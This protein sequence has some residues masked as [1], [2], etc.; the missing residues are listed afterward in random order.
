VSARLNWGTVS[1]ELTTLRTTG[2]PS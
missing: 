2:K 1:A